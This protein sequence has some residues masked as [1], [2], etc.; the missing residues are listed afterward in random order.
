MVCGQVDVCASVLV[1]CRVPSHTKK[2][3]NTGVKTP[4]RHQLKFLLFIELCVLPQQWDLDVNFQRARRQQPGLFGDFYETSS[5]N[6]FNAT[7]SQYWKVC[8]LT[9]DSH[10][11][12]CLLHYLELSLGSYSFNIGCFHCSNFHFFLQMPPIIGLSL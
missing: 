10:L 8:L 6:K 11:E 5:T 2:H 3:Q 9:R 1:A 7:K 4:C 12:L